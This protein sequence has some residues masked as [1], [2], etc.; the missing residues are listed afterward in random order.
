MK[1]NYFLVGLIFI[2]F[3]VISFLTNI[4]GPLIPDIIKSFSLSYFMV[5]FLPFAFF[6]AYI[7]SIP[8]GM[9]LEKYNE[10]KIMVAAFLIAAVGAFLFALIPVYSIA[11]VSLFLIGFGMAMLQVAI[12]P[13]LRTAGG[14]EHFAFNSV[15]AQL[16]FGG[17]SFLSPQLYSYL[18]KN[19]ESGHTN[20]NILLSS[21]SNLIPQGLPWVSLYWI[22]ALISV[23]M[24][25]VIAVIK[26]PK[27]ELKED[28]RTGA[29]KTIK[30]LLKNKTVIL[31]FIGIFAYVGTEQGIA[32]WISEFLSRYHGFDPQTTG[33]DT[34]SYYWGLLTVGCVLGLILLKLFDSKLVLRIFAIAAMISLAIALFSE[35]NV[36]LYFFPAAGF[37]LSVMWSVVFSL[38][39]NS[40]DKHHGSFSG[41]LCTGI[42]GGAIV[43]LIIGSLADIIGLRFGMLFIFI[44]LGYILSVSFWANPLIKNETIFEKVNVEI[45]N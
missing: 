13:L 18:V 16:F 39:L 4:I 30:E 28:E 22:F 26:L 32:N 40:V 2:I 14:E 29:W 5:A 15:F 34:V 20:N 41:I 1:R 19:L 6:I 44:T 3:F 35:G 23:L 8:A 45:N 27:V 11:I 31:F 9:L 38:A 7:M 17:A 36:P 43:P 37:F 33:A 25:I 21:L 12:N 10:K 42:I 24:V